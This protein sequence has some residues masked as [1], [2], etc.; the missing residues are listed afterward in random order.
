MKNVRNVVREHH[1][2]AAT[3]EHLAEDLALLQVAMTS[4]LGALEKSL[5]S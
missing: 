5:P 4:Y 1:A 3:H 2:N